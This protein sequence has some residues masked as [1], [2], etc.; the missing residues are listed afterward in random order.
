MHRTR[1]LVVDDHP[2]I[3]L[4]L[5][6]LLESLPDFAVCG[7]ADSVDDALAAIEAVKPELVITDLSLNGASG[8]D[9]I[10]RLAQRDGD[11]PVVVFSLHAEP[12]LVDSAFA[13]GARGYVSKEEPPDALIRAIRLVLAGGRYPSASPAK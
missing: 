6:Q 9:L 10:R 11:L 5:R 3:R 4:A 13:A 12:T 8:L 1:I 7:Q 2:T